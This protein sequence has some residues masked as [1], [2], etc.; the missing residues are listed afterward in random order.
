MRARH[1][2]TL[3]GGDSRGAHGCYFIGISGHNGRLEVSGVIEKLTE[4]QYRS[5]P[6]VN[7]SRLKLMARSPRQYQLDAHS[8]SPAKEFG[9]LVHQLTFE[10]ETYIRDHAYVVYDG[11]RRGN[12]WNAFQMEHVGERIMIASEVRS[13]D[14]SAAEARQLAAAVRAHPIVAPLLSDGQAEL[15][16]TWRDHITSLDCK[17]RLDWWHP[18]SATALDLK[19]SRDIGG[20]ERDMERF[21]YWLQ[22]AWYVHGLQEHEHGVEPRFIFVVAEKGTAEVVCCEPTMGFGR[23]L[24]ECES[25]LRL[26]RRYTLSGL[27]VWPSMSATIPLQKIRRGEVRYALTREQ[28]EEPEQSELPW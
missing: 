17:A 13:L 23:S 3:W 7:I 22:W 18:A 19:T 24:G 6:A 12:A 28:P 27:P 14:E 25:L 15:S 2:P 26:V 20:F 11:V 21:G 10:P 8:D 1:D 16:V 5:L 4:A 9:R